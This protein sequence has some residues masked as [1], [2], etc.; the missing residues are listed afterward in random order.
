MLQVISN[1][2]FIEQ[3]GPIPKGYE[4]VTFPHL[5]WQPGLAML[6]LFTM[7]AAV[8][9]MVVVRQH[10]SASTR[11]CMILDEKEMNYCVKINCDMKETD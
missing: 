4:M 10:Q 11:S 9:V 5:A 6:S 2:G 7:A 1:Q 8:E 3:F